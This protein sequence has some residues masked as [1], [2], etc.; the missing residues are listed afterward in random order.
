[1]QHRRFCLGLFLYV[2]LTGSAGCGDSHSDHPVDASVAPPPGADAAAP[3]PDDAAGGDG[4][5]ALSRTA[6]LGA[7]GSCALTTAMEAASAAAELETAIKQLE[8]QPAMPEA[9]QA[10]FRKALD[11]WELV[12]S[13]Q[14]GPAARKDLPGGGGLRDYIYAWPSLHR[15]SVEEGLV[16]N[17]FKA[18]DFLSTALVNRRGF[19]ALEYLLFFPGSAGGCPASAALAMLPA[20]EREARKRAY[21]TILAADL[22]ARTAALANAWDPTKGN[23]VNTLASAGPGNPVYPSL[24]VAFN[25]VGNALFYL[26]REVKDIKLAQPLGLRECMQTTCPELL[27]SQFAARSKANI[28]ANLAGFRRLI[29][30]CGPDYSGVAFDDLLQAL[31]AGAVAATLH[32]RILAAGASLDAVEEADLEEALEKD[33]ASVRAVYDALK[34]V[35]DLLK[36]Q[37]RDVLNIDL[38]KDL[39]TDND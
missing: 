21:A 22:R 36:T 28:R 6:V 35:T 33:L 12:E 39:A 18:P 29:E 24:Q 20:E 26:E 30:G 1:M 31:N 10:A 2:G 14:F 34:G 5:P 23:F 17:S 13:M 27:E 4:P 37:F 9:A 19:G 16:A 25:A 38:P 7:L 11:A 3:S 15:C 8:A 32:E